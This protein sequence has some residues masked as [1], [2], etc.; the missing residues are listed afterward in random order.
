[1]RQN[2]KRAQI[3]AMEY[4]PVKD[5]QVINFPGTFDIKV[6]GAFRKI[7][8]SAIEF[9]E[10]IEPGT[11]IEQELNATVTDTSMMTLAELRILFF[12]EGLLLLKMTNG[13]EK[14]VGTDQFPVLITSE[15]SGS[16]AM[17][18]LS[19]KRNSPEPAKILK[20]F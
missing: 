15:I 5:A 10:K 3:Y 17:I 9:K 1:M 2:D 16:P 7:P 13:E 14:V 18:K 11:L 6:A 19:F 4:L 12:Q 8:V 20:S